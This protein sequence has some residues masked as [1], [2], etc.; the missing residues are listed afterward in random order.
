MD[1]RG[2]RNMAVQQKS[3]KFSP[4]Q[5]FISWLEK[6]RERRRRWEEGVAVAVKKIIGDIVG[7]FFS[8]PSS[9]GGPENE[10]GTQEERGIPDR[11]C[12]MRRGRNFGRC[13]VQQ[14]PTF[15]NNSGRRFRQFLFKKTPIHAVLCNSLPFKNC[16]S[17]YARHR[18]KNSGFFCS[19]APWQ[20]SQNATHCAENSAKSFRSLRFFFPSSQPSSFILKSLV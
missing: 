15:A 19:P 10:R 16:T 14:F 9:L 11:F 20:L 6:N 8:K 12:E 18:T 1:A 2:V 13:N 17:K 4:F 5:P 3:G 7:F